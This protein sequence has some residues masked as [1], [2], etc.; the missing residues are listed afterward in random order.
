MLPKVKIIGKSTD[1]QLV[2]S[3]IFKFFDTTGVP[4]FVIFDLC[5]QHNWLPSWIHLYKEAQMQ[6]WKHKTIINRLREGMQ[7]IYEKE[8][9]LKVIERLNSVTDS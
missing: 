7:D 2:V 3:G 6:G 9:I 8:F 5:K 4:L 1:G